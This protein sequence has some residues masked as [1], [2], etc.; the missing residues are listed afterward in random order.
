MWVFL[1]QGKYQEYTKDLVSQKENVVYHL[2]S[3]LTENLV[4]V[5]V[6][7]NVQSSTPE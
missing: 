3:F 2:S 4:Y 5:H 1:K 6:V 7:Y